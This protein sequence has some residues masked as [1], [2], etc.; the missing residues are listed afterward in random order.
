M[1]KAEWNAMKNDAYELR[2]VYAME[3]YVRIR[4]ESTKSS[5]LCYT[6]AAKSFSISKSN[7]P[8]NWQTL[9]RW[10]MEYAGNGGRIP[11]RQ[12]ERRANL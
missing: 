6:E 5:R 7:K 4:K 2:K 9:R 3:M 10:V 8:I 11:R 12:R 1:T